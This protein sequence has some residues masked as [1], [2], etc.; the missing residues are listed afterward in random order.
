MAGKR[1]RRHRARHGSRRPTLIAQ[2]G[3]DL[4][5]GEVAVG[6]EALRDR[7]NLVQLPLKRTAGG[8]NTVAL[9]SVLSLKIVANR[10][11]GYPKIPV[12][13]SS[14]K[15]NRVDHEPWVM[16]SAVFSP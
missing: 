12:I 4:I 9:P 10:H 3:A 11:D 5:T 6:R 16:V 2:G 15:Q 14:G 7:E 1:L 8:W 13:M